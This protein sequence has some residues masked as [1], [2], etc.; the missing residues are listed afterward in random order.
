MRSRITNGNFFREEINRA[1]VNTLEH[2][3]SQFNNSIMDTEY[4]I[5]KYV[6]GSGNFYLLESSFRSS[7]FVS[8]VVVSRFL[9]FRRESL[10]AHYFFL[11]E[12][13]ISSNI[14]C[15]DLFIASASLLNHSSL[16]L[17]TLE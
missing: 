11:L 9:Y 10:C 15:L 2:S 8:P 6:E 4:E 17:S 5:H 13:I 12:S 7:L 16:W 14:L 1:C 3:I